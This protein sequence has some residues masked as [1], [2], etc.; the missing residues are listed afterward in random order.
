[1]CPRGWSVG[2][3]ESPA[4]HVLSVCQCALNDGAQL[5]L[6]SDGGSFVSPKSSALQQHRA[7]GGPSSC[8]ATSIVAAQVLTKEGEPAQLFSTA[9]LDESLPPAVAEY[10][11]KLWKF[12]RVLQG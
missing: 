7:G 9:A 1:L 6:G 3:T 8:V 5:V 11:A 10:R 2:C 4:T 12:A